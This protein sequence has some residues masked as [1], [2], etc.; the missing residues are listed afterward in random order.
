[1]RGLFWLTSPNA[2]LVIAHHYGVWRVEWEGGMHGLKNQEWFLDSAWTFR[3]K[4]GGLNLSIYS[5]QKPHYNY[6]VRGFSFKDMVLQ[7]YGEWE[8]RK[9][10]H[11]IIITTIT[12]INWK[13]KS[14]W[15]MVHNLA[16]LGKPNLRLSVK[17][18]K[19]EPD[20]YYRIFKS[21]RN[22]WQERIFYS[23][24]PIFSSSPVH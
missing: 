24:P 23:R 21:L 10:A 2:V 18:A 5:F 8:R 16:A 14:K 11:K 12:I 20:F 6:I 19:K 1:M 22:W 3:E 7:G 9:Q 4:K 13:L 17:K 15:S